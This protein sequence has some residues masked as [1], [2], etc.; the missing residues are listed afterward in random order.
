MPVD[1]SI[2]LAA[3]NIPGNAMNNMVSMYEFAAKL[4][5][6]QRQQQAQNALR[7]IFQDP[8]A[9][10]PQT[11]MPN[12]QAVGKMMQIDPAY[13]ME[14]QNNILKMQHEREQAD[15]Q[16]AMAELHRLGVTEKQLEY[17]NEKDGEAHAY[18][19][20][21]IAKGTPK[22]QALELTNGYMAKL[23]DE[24]KSSGHL[25]DLADKLGSTFNPEE[26]SHLDS[27][28]YKNYLAQQ[29]QDRKGQRKAEEDAKKA[30][31]TRNLILGDKEATETWNPETLTWEP[32]GKP[33]PRFSKQIVNVNA[34]GP[35]KPP[36]GYRWSKQTPGNLEPIP[37]GPATKDR[38]DVEQAD[39]LSVYHA[40]YPFGYMPEVYGKD[41]PT[42]DQFI[43]QH[44]HGMPSTP[45]AGNVPKVSSKA[46]ADKLPKGA[47]F[48]DA[49]DGKE[50]IK[51]W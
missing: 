3:G 22:G 4:K 47:H 45:V 8:N 24:M 13:G 21:L 36:A 25:G 46:E 40:R 39:A 2:P 42:P 1:A 26:K 19:D 27:R 7:S 5:S 49:R 18:Y 10:D 17:V 48:I 31:T 50:K 20:D 30:P 6:Q 29:N 51:G 16:R 43:G 34:A 44:G 11:G 35:D 32:V 14:I 23:H 28:A 37:G 33:G 9:I 38:R 41:Q 15:N 12:Q